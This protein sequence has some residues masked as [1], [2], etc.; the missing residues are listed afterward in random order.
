VIQLTSAQLDAWLAAFFWPMARVLALVATA[1]VLGNNGVPRRIRL[2]LGLALTVAIAPLAGPFPDVSPAS[3]QGLLILG[4]QVMIGVAMGFAMRIVFTAV[5]MAGELIGLQMG[6]GFATFFDHVHGVNSPVVAQLLGLI[7][8]LFFLAINGHLLVIAALAESFQ[9]MPVGTGLF[10]PQA[11]YGLVSWGGHIFTAGF[12]LALPV[13]AALVITNV[14]LG[15][16]TRTAPQLNVFAV[17]FPIT[18]M[19]GFLMLALVLPYM[20]GPLEG[21]LTSGVQTA[22]RII[23]P[24]PLPSP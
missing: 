6:L 22:L 23:G 17:G 7:A 16:L 15:V 10:G 14:A 24:S 4:Q 19:L 1:P 9:V 12:T 5:D 11:A 2:G 8:M 3:W 21:L 13:L 20:T 18:L